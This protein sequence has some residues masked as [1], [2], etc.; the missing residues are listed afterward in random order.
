[1][2]ALRRVSNFRYPGS[3][4]RI[5]VPFAVGGGADTQA[6]V[7]A[8]SLAESL[9]VSVIVDNKPGG[10]SAIGTREVQ[11]AAPDGHT[12]L[13]TI[14]TI[15][16]VPLLSRRPLWNMFTDFT[17]ITTAVRV[18]AVLTAHVSAPFNTLPDLIA[19]AKANP[20]KLSYASFGTGSSAHLNGENLKRRAGI[21]I[22]HVPYKGVG[23]AMRDQLSGNVILAFD[24]PMTAMPNVQS[25]LVKFIAIAA[26]A[27]SAATPDVPTLR[28]HG[29]DIGRRGYNWF[30]GPPGMPPAIVDAIYSH[31][32]K[33]VGRPEVKGAF[34]KVGHEAIALTPTEM[35]AEVQRTHDYWAPIVRELGVTLD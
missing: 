10:S 34:E 6:R 32:A 3:Q 8:Q 15:V 27:R 9:G 21:D 17:P 30:F 24:S 16:Q 33:A 7:I 31:I 29:Y 25:G 35:A 28:E 2:Q 26:E 4:I 12:L 23:E 11:R 22:V 13:Y 19:Y 5:A 20:G 18:S 1:M 14:G